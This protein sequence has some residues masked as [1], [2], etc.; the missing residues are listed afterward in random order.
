[1]RRL[2][3]LAAFA[4]PSPA[5]AATAI[6]EKGDTAWMLVATLLVVMMAMPGLGLF[7]GGLVRAKNMLS[8]LT[9]IMGVAA[10]T[11]LAW[12][13]WGYSLAFSAGNAW[14][15]DTA[16]AFFRGVGPTSTVD[17]FTKGC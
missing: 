5:A 6:A 12:L 7:Y 16:K 13:G 3:L 9:Q 15:G 1:M 11:F 17:T 4:I 8:I 10:V 14:V 2:L